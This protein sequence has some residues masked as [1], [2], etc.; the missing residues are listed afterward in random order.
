M[1]VETLLVKEDHIYVGKTSAVYPLDKIQIATFSVVLRFEG[2]TESVFALYFSGGTLYSGSADTTIISWNSE[3]GKIIKTFHGHSDFVS[4]LIVLEDTMY[5]SGND[6]TV[7]EW[8]IDSGEIIKIFTELADGKVR[9]IGSKNR[10]LFTGLEETSVVMWNTTTG[11]SLLKYSGKQKMLTSVVLWKSSVMNGGDDSLIRI[12]D[13]T[14]DNLDPYK[15]LTDHTETIGCLIVYGDTLFSGS[16]DLSIRH[17]NLTDL[18]CL[19]IL[20]G[21]FLFS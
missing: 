2:H 15:V 3:S 5:S 6:R 7:I 16:G 19:K 21:K 17:W 14:F 11:L 1:K 20:F 9:C 8:S 10:L 12:W 13:A 4:A 18:I